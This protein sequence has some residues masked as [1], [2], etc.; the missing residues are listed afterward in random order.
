[1]P[2]KQV[3][4]EVHEAV[5]DIFCILW[6]S[7]GHIG[8]QSHVQSRHCQSRKHP[9]SPPVEC[10]D[11][12]GNDDG[13]AH[14]ESSAQLVEQTGLCSRF[15]ESQGEQIHLL[16]LTNVLGIFNASAHLRRIVGPWKCILGTSQWTFTGVEY[17]LTAQPFS[18]LSLHPNQLLLVGILGAPTLQSCCGISEQD[19]LALEWLFFYKNDIKKRFQRPYQRTKL[20]RPYRCCSDS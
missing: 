6:G 13:A 10:L 8:N 7:Q 11:R 14:P 19:N 2:R 4:S 3:I 18:H 15:H 9:R 16:I 1:M 12:I 5:E 20:Q 17:L